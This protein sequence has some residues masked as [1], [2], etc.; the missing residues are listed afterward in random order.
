MTLTTFDIGF[1][2]GSGGF[3]GGC[4]FGNEKLQY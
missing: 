4:T 2:V 3:I 1:D